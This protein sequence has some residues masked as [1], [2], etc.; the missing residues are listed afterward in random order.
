MEY[1]KKSGFATLV[2]RPNVGKSTLMNHLIG[3][4]I[5]ITS[6]KPQTT[7]NRIQ[8]VYTDERGQIIFLDTPGIHKAKNKL[9]EYMVNVAEHTLKEVDVILWLV[10]PTTFIGAGERHIA[11]Q[12]NRVKTPVI[13]V[14]NKIDTVKNQ[15]EILTFINAYKDI[16]PFAEIVPVSALRKRNTDVLLEQIFKYLPYGPQYYDED[17]VTDQ[18]MRQIAAELIREKALRL[19]SDE[20]PHGIA[21]TIEKMTERENGIMDIEASIICEKDSHKGIIIGKGGS[22]LKKIGSAA[23]REIEDMMETQVNLQLWVKVR[24]EWRD[25]EIYM[26]NYGYDAKDV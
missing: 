10:E 1:T 3:Q 22:M 9:G 20:I 4:K 5:A 6:D 12:L 25:S 23:R 18:P 8:T 24:R 13:L 2:G 26:K 17:T 11:E 16:C 7:R 15:D 21:V 14:I 19:L